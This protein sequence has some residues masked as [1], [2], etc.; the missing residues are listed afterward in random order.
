MGGG[1]VGG[2]S[3]RVGHDWACAHN[4]AKQ[5]YFNKLFTSSAA[6][7]DIQ[8]K[9]EVFFFFFFNQKKNGGP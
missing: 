9:G 4:T 7:L 2:G 1:G 6:S 3:H 8:N 5:L